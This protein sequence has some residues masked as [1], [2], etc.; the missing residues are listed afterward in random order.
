MGD[1]VIAV[2]DLRVTFRGLAALDG[3][4]LTLAAGERKA[5]IGPNGAGKT[6]MFNVLSCVLRPTSGRVDLFGQNAGRLS[7]HGRARRGLSRTYQITNLLSD[8][9]VRE[10]VMLGVAATRRSTRATFWRRLDAMPGVTE[11]AEEILRE[12]EMWHAR[13][14]TVSELAYGQQ[15]VLEI[16][17]ALTSDPKV[18]LLDEPTAGLSKRDAGM[19]TDVAASL[20][21]SLALLVIEHDMD[22][23][24][25]LAESVT[26]LADGK[27]LAEGPPAE[28]RSSRLVIE[29]YLGEHDVA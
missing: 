7:I 27:V 3:V 20:P 26:V 8:L 11:R 16:V 25:K 2:T 17:L 15:R 10:N 12:W 29:T 28:I 22:V 24:F 18:L 21:A 14:R 19:L 23:A 9:S 1:P 6:T 4:S 13:D 5:L